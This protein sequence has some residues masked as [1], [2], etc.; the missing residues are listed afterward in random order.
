MGHGLTQPGK[1]LVLGSQAGGHTWE[2]SSPD[3]SGPEKLLVL[4]LKAGRHAVE[5]WD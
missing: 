1:L 2:A 3:L 5:T 4:D